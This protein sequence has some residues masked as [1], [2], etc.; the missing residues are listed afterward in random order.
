MIAKGLENDGIS[1]YVLNVGGNVR[2]VGTK[3]DGEKWVVGIEN[4]DENSEESYIAYLELSGESLVTSGSYQRYYTVDSKR[5]HHIIDPET[6][7]PSDKFLSVSVVCKSS[8]DGDAISTALFC[9]ELNEGL[10]FVNSLSGVEAMWVDV[11]GNIHYS[12]GFKNYIK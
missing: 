6:L 11:D 7:M 8:A 9:M 1:G 12:S 3:G 4:P 2:T 10:E 5:Y